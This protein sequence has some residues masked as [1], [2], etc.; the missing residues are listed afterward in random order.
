MSHL[1]KHACAVEGA[2]LSLAIR[3]RERVRNNGNASGEF[4]VIKVNGPSQ[5]AHGSVGSAQKLVRDSRVDG[6]TL[7]LHV[8]HERSPTPIGG[9]VTVSNVNA[10]SRGL[11]GEL[12]GRPQ[13]A[14]VDADAFV[15][16][17][18]PAFARK[19]LPQPPR[20]NNKERVS[21]QHMLNHVLAKRPKAVKKLTWLM[22]RKS[23]R[24][25]LQVVACHILTLTRELEYCESRW[26]VMSCVTLEMF[27]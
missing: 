8:N 1:H 17:L 24:L 22:M 9:G 5:V 4:I 27:Q 11:F 2:G 15:L 14:Q 21:A 26:T 12:L 7:V 16:D 19:G 18:K 13:Y 6:V 10:A 20:R 25:L 3:E 23:R